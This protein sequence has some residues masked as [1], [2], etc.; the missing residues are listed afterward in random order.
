M[1]PVSI[2][3]M[4]S[5]SFSFRPNEQG[6]AQKYFILATR[7]MLSN[8]RMYSIIFCN[9]AKVVRMWLHQNSVQLKNIISVQHGRLFSVSHKEQ[10]LHFQNKTFASFVPMLYEIKSGEYQFILQFTGSIAAG[11]QFL[12]K[13]Q[14]CRMVVLYSRHFRILCSRFVF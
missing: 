11:R 1:P 6:V 13:S 7:N 8:L 3:S 2:T 12:G 10:F 9:H 4:V 14:N 5:H